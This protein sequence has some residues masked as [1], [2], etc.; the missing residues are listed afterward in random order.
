MKIMPRIFFLLP[1]LFLP[2]VSEASYFYCHYQNPEVDT[3]IYD[4][5]LH[6]DDETRDFDFRDKNLLNIHHTSDKN[7]VSRVYRGVGRY[8]NFV[9]YRFH[10]NGRKFHQHHAYYIPPEELKNF[11]GGPGIKIDDKEMIALIKEKKPKGFKS[12]SWL[13]TTWECRKI[14]FF[15][16][17]YHGFALLFR[18]MLL[19]D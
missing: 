7:V 18:Q 6:Y 17:I 12:L 13:K 4:F 10:P 19:I 15:Q 14:S 5:T 11:P 2:I 16:N 1:S 3:D 9:V 8:L